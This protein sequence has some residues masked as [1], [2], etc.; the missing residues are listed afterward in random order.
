MRISTIFVDC[1]RLLKQCEQCRDPLLHI[2]Q[3]YSPVK[4]PQKCVGDSTMVTFS[5]VAQILYQT[6]HKIGFNRVTE[7][8]RKCMYRGGHRS[9]IGS[10][11]RILLCVE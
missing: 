3:G 4:L 8:F 9:R 7:S 1:D 11:D 5:D 10:N 2:N 6:Q